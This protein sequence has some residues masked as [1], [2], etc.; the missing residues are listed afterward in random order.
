ME[1]EYHFTCPLAAGLHARPATQLA[2]AARRHSALV[3]LVNERTGDMADCASVL[4]LVSAGVQFGDRCTLRFSGADAAA[5]RAEVAE[6]IERDLPHCDDL[7]SPAPPAQPAR[8]P[9]SL[10]D[11]GLEWRAGVPLSPGIARGALVHISAAQLPAELPASDA[12]RDAAAERARL[13]AAQASVVAALTQQAAAAADTA[14]REILEAAL[15]IVQ[16]PGLAVAWD[17]Q[18]AAAQ[19]AAGAVVHAARLWMQRLAASSNAY[20]RE[21]QADVEDVALR[22]LAVLGVPLPGS[23]LPVFAVPS[24]LCAAQLSPAQLLALDRTLLR[25]LVLG[26]AS[27]TTHTVIL[28]RSRGLPVLGGVEETESLPAGA[29][30][31]LDAGGGVLIAPLTPQAARYYELEATAVAARR[32]RLERNAG[33]AGLT[34]DGRRIEIAA[35]LSLASEAENALEL[36][37]EG[38]GLFRTEML[39]AARDSAPS[40]DEQFAEYAAVVEA[41]QGYPV[42]IRTF[43]VGGDK[44]LPYLRLPQETNP[45][46]GYRGIRMYDQHAELIDTQLRAIC[47]ASALG[48]VRLMAPMV[49]S[50]DEARAFHHRVIDVQLRLKAE[51]VAFDDRMPIGVMLEVPSAAFAVGQLASV[52]DFFSIGSND[53]SQYF[54]AADRGNPRVAGINSERH[55]AFLRL[56]KLAVDEARLHGRWIGL[57][58]EMARDPRHTPL[59][60]G[61]GLNELSLAAP[62]IAAVKAAVAR[63]D[64][65]ECRTLLEQAA[66]CSSEAEVDALLHSFAARQPAPPLLAPE[67]VVLDADCRDKPEVLR[68]L[69]SLLYAQERTDAPDTIEDA[70][71]TREE[72]FSTGLGH[73]LA[74][75]HCKSAAVAASSLA[76]LRLRQPVEWGALDAAPVDCAIMLAMPEDAQREHLQVFAKLARK[77]MDEQFRA[78]L[79]NAQSTSGVLEL[80]QRELELGG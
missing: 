40:E 22:L 10:A 48:P 39:Y 24:L 58:G 55:P 76:V 53:L 4:S 2:R 64:S 31:V 65:Q 68:A 27:S 47:R 26:D 18:L 19:T 12:S 5:A 15:A 7:P 60:A 14:E 9:R 54:F 69:A 56:L 75:P 70:L 11:T 49:A 1:L 34:R 28:A 63:L 57:C 80:L 36:G 59:L 38:V 78:A 42:I 77:L 44:P 51:G 20:L 25:G 23:S 6:F 13:A 32:A 37:A 46:L 45:F 21:R 66:V 52:C 43:D 73:G 3:E 35:N 30:A 41:M 67:L 62:G 29:D 72:Q 61:L 71:W 79:H 16:D 8:L 74:I 50:L 33:L 17:E